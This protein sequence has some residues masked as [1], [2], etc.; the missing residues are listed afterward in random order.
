[1]S[2]RCLAIGYVVT[3]YGHCQKSH[4]VAR[5]QLTS[6]VI[7]S[8]A[9]RSFDFTLCLTQHIFADFLFLRTPQSWLQS[10]SL[11]APRDVGEGERLWGE[12]RGWHWKSWEVLGSAN[13][14]NPRWTLNKGSLMYYR[15]GFSYSI[16]LRRTAS[17]C[18]LWVLMLR[19]GSL[20]LLNCGLQMLAIVCWCYLVLILSTA[21]CVTFRHCAGSR[22]DWII[23][24]LVPVS[25][26][27]KLNPGDLACNFFFAGCL[28]LHSKHSAQE[29][30]KQHCSK[31]AKQSTSWYFMHPH[32]ISWYLQAKDFG[33]NICVGVIKI[34]TKISH[35]LHCKGHLS[36]TWGWLCREVL[37]GRAQRWYKRSINDSQWWQRAN[38]SQIICGYMQ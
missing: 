17:T 31:E 12:N 26:T 15:E 14:R 22:V 13:V 3:V 4:N 36:G 34:H 32:D 35:I 24:L 2:I 5:R 10:G 8:V 30:E 11:K 37:T 23:L 28:V 18:H 20:G 21:Y 38:I 7:A 6:L 1:M 9:A 33:R 19:M 25:F 29:L 16:Q 27:A